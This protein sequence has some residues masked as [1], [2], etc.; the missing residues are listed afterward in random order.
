[1]HA[2]VRPQARLLCARSC[3]I[4]RCSDAHPA[5]GWAFGCSGK[6][7]APPALDR[8]AAVACSATPAPAR[9]A[10][11]LRSRDVADAAP[12]AGSAGSFAGAHGRGISGITAQSHPRFST[13]AALSALLRQQPATGSHEAVH[14]RLPCG[15]TAQSRSRCSASAAKQISALHSIYPC[16]GSCDLYATITPLFSCISAADGRYGLSRVSIPAAA[17]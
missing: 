15:I 4:I 16:C 17:A 11:P 7:S 8:Q 1:V 9:P 6:K 2:S 14:R 13:A 10:A 5:G 12:A 3:L